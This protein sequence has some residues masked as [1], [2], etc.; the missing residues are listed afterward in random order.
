MSRRLS[1]ATLPLVA[2]VAT[3]CLATRGDVRLL[4]DELRA[5]RTAAAQ[6]DAGRREQLDSLVRTLAR[7][8]QQQRRLEDSIRVIASRL[9]SFQ[10]TANE[11]FSLLNN[12]VLEAAELSRRGQEYISSLRAQNE[13]IAQRI[14]AATMMSGTAI[15]GGDT[16][17]PPVTGGMV[18]DDGPAQL[19]T[20]GREQFTRNSCRT[21]RMAFEELYAKY[22]TDPLAPDALYYVGASFACE[23]NS[24]AADSIYAMVVRQYPQS[25]KAPTALWKRADAMIKANRREAARPL[26]NDII[27]RYPRSDEAGLACEALGR[28]TR[29]P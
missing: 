20:S 14:D 15:P 12:R 11:N 29:C 22:P 2:L 23:A 24:A 4:Q 3:G 16:A 8:E 25:D 7:N 5:S 21:A 1:L 27:T 6:A 19:F 28:T 9:A 10:T 18:R 17:R 13:A 26:L